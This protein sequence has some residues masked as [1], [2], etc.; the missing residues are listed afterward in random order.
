MADVFVSYTAGDRTRV[1]QLVNALQANGLS[2]WWDRGIG[3]G[4]TFDREIERELD[5]AKCVVVVWSN[6]SVDSEWVRNEAVEVPGQARQEGAL[7]APR[8]HLPQ[9]LRP[10]GWLPTGRG[11]QVAKSKAP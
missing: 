10:A 9:A 6:A 7:L 1:A 3:V 5:A 11:S 8:R 4:S 2:V